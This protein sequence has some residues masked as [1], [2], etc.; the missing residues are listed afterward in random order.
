M[1]KT[2]RYSLER[3]AF[4]SI[5][6]QKRD[7]QFRQSM[8]IESPMS[9]YSDASEVSAVKLARER[10]VL[11]KDSNKK[12]KTREEEEKRVAVAAANI[13]GHEFNTN[14]FYFRD[15]EIDPGVFMRYFRHSIPMFVKELTATAVL[16]LLFALTIIIRRGDVLKVSNGSILDALVYGI[17][18]G[19]LLQLFPGVHMNPSITLFSAIQRIIDIVIDQVKGYRSSKT[20]GTDTRKQARIWSTFWHALTILLFA[21]CQLVAQGVGALCAL[22]FLLSLSFVT[23]VSGQPVDIGQVPRPGIALLGNNDD[24]FRL[25]AIAIVLITVMWWFQVSTL[26]QLTQSKQNDEAHRLFVSRCVSITFALVTLVFTPYT[27]GSFNWIGRNYVPAFVLQGR[28]S[29]Y[30]QDVDATDSFQRYFLSHLCGVG[31]GL[32]FVLLYRI[33]TVTKQ[34][35][36]NTTSTKTY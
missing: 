2:P 12:T 26:K 1:S 35:L 5:E 10:A 34:T 31:F 18:Y 17:A 4:D 13:P 36:T 7:G 3:I 28:L 25:E 20:L 33:C 32:A 24:V 6:S 29:S 11:A 16:T 15:N 19:T 21:C 27:G 23:P 9:I 14:Y 8:S 30:S 22:L